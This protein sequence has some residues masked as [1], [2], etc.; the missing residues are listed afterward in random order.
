MDLYE[1]VT[2]IFH[3]HIDTSMRSMEELPGNIAEAGQLLTHCL[4][5]DKKIL[6]CGED[7]SGSL[8]QIFSSHLLHRFNYERP[9][10]AAICLSTNPTLITAITKEGNFSEI[11]AKQIRA[12]GQAGDILLVLAND[13]NTPSASQAIQTAH[14]RDMIVI[15]VN[16]SNNQSSA[17]LFPEDIEISIPTNN[18]SR[19]IEA[20]LLIINCLCE[21]IDFQLFGGEAE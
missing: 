20:Q 10:L 21:L 19:I 17:L 4:L 15:S 14:D 18:R 9:G 3:S 8:A 1:Q 6:C 2:E 11:F 5:S 13:S 16:G 7:Q 12:L